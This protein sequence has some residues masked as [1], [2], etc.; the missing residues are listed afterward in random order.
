VYNT[1]PFLMEKEHHPR[2]PTAGKSASE[3]PQTI[4]ES[5]AERHSDGPSELH[6]GEI[7]PDWRSAIGNVFNQ[8]LTGSAPPIVR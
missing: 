5:A 1:D 4:S 2:D 8:S 7:A 6:R 3:F